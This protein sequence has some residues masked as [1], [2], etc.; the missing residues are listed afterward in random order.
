MIIVITVFV[1]SCLF[2]CRAFCPNGPEFTA[3]DLDEI[4][5]ER[6]DTIERKIKDNIKLLKVIPFWSYS[7][8]SLLFFSS[9]RS[10]LSFLCFRR[11]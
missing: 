9:S 10:F 1:F 3:L 5:L 2:A 11:N 6:L 4:R 8:P 7:S